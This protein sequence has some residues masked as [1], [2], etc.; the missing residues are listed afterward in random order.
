MPKCDLDYLGIIKNIQAKNNNITSESE[1]YLSRQ[2][3]YHDRLKGIQTLTV[4]QNDL[5]VVLNYLATFT[6][7]S[8]TFSNFTVNTQLTLNRVTFT[9]KLLTDQRNEE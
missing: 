9:L 1:F 6:H 7:N 4:Y 2:Y 8:P 5:K 3:I